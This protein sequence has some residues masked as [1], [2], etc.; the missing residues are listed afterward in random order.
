MCVSKVRGG[1]S[2]TCQTFEMARSMRAT[3][4]RT[5]NVS[6]ED[7]LPEAHVSFVSKP[8]ASPEYYRSYRGYRS[9]RLIKL[10]ELSELSK[11]SELSELSKLSELLELLD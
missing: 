8:P 5:A 7:G 2:I 1:K 10:S 11:L 9:Y 6:A 3:A 4:V